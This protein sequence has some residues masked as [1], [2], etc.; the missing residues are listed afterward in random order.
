[1]SYIDREFGDLRQFILNTS[2]PDI[3]FP[4]SHFI[5]FIPVKIDVSN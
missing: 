3:Y 2:F 1:M 4:R 5:K